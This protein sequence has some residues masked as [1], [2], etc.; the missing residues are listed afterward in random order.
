MGGT[1]RVGLERKWG[2]REDEAA[3]GQPGG[4]RIMDTR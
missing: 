4:T 1:C 2:V 3:R